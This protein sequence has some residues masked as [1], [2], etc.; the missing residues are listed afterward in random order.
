[1][2]ERI[3]YAG[4]GPLDCPRRLRDYLNDHD[5]PDSPATLRVYGEYLY[6]FTRPESDELALVTVYVLPAEYRSLARIAQR[7]QHALAA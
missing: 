7:D 3:F 5:R 6:I 4:V 1:M 2:L